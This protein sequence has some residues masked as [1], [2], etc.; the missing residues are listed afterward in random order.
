[1]INVD[2]ITDDFSHQREHILTIMLL[3]Y[4]DDY[5][6]DFYIVADI[7]KARTSKINIDI[8]H[9]KD[10]LLSKLYREYRFDY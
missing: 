8:Q 7:V 1:M 3:K 9:I 6:Y 5:Y 4:F 2:R 10:R